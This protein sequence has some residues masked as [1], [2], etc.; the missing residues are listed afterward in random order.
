[1]LADAREQ[2]RRS[3][4]AGT[5]LGDLTEATGLSRGSLYGAFG[6]K[7]DL[8]VRVFDDYC[9]EGRDAEARQLAGPGRAYDQLVGHLEQMA[10]SHPAERAPRACMLAKATA[11]LAEREP[12]VAGRAATAFGALEDLYA[13]VLARAQAEGD[14]AAD[15]DPRAL[16]G[17]LLVVVRG[18]EAVAEA[19]APEAELLRTVRTVL[20]C[21]PR[22]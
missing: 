19:G 12:A 15:A 10:R 4:Y 20:A 5:S 9:T 8:F 14:L 6:G 11:E 18:I 16:A 3:G 17:M 13:D 1:V 22:T 2:F 21:L 7:L